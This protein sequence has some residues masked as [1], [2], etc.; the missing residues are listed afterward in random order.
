M[1]IESQANQLKKVVKEKD[2]AL[3]KAKLLS[4]E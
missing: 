2:K 3:L 1:E 4:K